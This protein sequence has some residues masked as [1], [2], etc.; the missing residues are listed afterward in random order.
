MEDLFEAIEPAVEAA[1]AVRPGCRLLI[2][3]KTSSAIGLLQARNAPLVVGFLHQQFKRSRSIAISHSELL[4]ALSSFQERL[5]EIG[6]DGLRD[7]P[8]EYLR[9][10]SSPEKRWLHRFLEAGRNEPMY[11]LTPH[12]EAVIEFLE[13]ALQQDLAFVGTES[14]LRLVIQALEELLIGASD[15]FLDH[16]RSN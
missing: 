9:D 7:K 6:C 8:E 4:P 3:F 11:Q 2:H 12:S 15:E 10:W 14:L 5:Q 13:R 1:P 16:T